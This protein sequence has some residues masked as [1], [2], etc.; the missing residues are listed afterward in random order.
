MDKV[1][2]AIIGK[3]WVNENATGLQ[4]ASYVLEQDMVFVKG[5]SFLLNGAT[6]RIDRNLN[7]STELGKITPLALQKGTRLTFFTNSKRE[8][9]KDADFTVSVVLPEAEAT[10]IIE[11]NKRGQAE[12]R[13]QN[14]ISVGGPE[15]TEEFSPTPAP[16]QT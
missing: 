11:N 14:Q 3:M 5:D 4:P 1:K 7:T 2:S 9:I 6:I 10:I 13:K 8:G 16:A 15:P 12:W